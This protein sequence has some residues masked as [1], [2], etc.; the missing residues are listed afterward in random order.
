MVAEARAASGAEPEP[1]LPHGWQGA[2]TR[3]TTTA[4]QGLS[5]Q[6]AG[7]RKTK[8]EYRVWHPGI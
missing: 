1:G 8:P 2:R 4:L 5:V 7:A 6:E 3:A